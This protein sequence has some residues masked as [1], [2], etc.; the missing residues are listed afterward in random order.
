[1]KL[2]ID[3][4]TLL[5]LLV[6]FCVPIAHSLLPTASGD[7]AGAQ[8]Y[9][10][11]APTTTTKVCGTVPGH[12]KCTKDKTI[13]PGKAETGNVIYCN[14]DTGDKSTD[15]KDSADC[16]SDNNAETHGC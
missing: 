3:V 2:L 10:C 11:N 5:M 9:K 8:T 4:K 15:C 6:V 7:V 12:E 1:M 14:D 16:T 13:C